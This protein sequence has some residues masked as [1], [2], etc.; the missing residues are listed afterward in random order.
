MRYEIDTYTFST[1]LNSKTLSKILARILD[2]YNKLDTEYS[3]VDRMTF[4]MED[5][6]KS[7]RY[8]NKST[9]SR[10]IAE[11]SKLGLFISTT[12][13]KGTTIYFN[14]EKIRRV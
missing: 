10:G 6:R 2:A 1:I 11:L 9:I 13:N 5:L 7:L 4:S 3:N 12:N 14:P 8:K